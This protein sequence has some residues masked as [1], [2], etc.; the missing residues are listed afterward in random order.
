MDKVSKAYHAYI[1]A[2]KEDR[3]GQKKFQRGE[4]CSGE[5]F[6]IEYNKHETEQEFIQ[7]LKKC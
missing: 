6:D 2:L 3:K 4:I 1:K 5:Y 7:C